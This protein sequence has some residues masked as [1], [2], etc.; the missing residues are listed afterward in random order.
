M[1]LPSDSAKVVHGQGRAGGARAELAAVGLPAGALSSEVAATPGEPPERSAGALVRIERHGE[2]L[3]GSPL[4]LSPPPPLAG[5]ELL[6]GRRRRRRCRRAAPPR[7]P[8]SNSASSTATSALL[9][10]DRRP[11][12]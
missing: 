4:P 1:R 11:P 5:A 8:G 12:S 6:R 10:A 2:H 3:H 9:M 7:R